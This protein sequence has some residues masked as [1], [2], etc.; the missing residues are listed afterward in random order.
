MIG[1]TR[2]M[3][4]QYADIDC[5]RH[6][7]AFSGEI[8]RRSCASVAAHREQQDWTNTDDQFWRVKV[9]SLA[10]CMSS[11]LNSRLKVL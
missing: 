6:Y 1:L 7:R 10:R 2:I 4:Q 11:I 9:S 5:D 3:L 8:G